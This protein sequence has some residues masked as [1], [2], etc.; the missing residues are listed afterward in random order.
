MTYVTGD[1]ER[2]FLA[3][4]GRKG[5][6]WQCTK[7]CFNNAALKE[8]D[9]PTHRHFASVRKRIE[10]DSKPRKEGDLLLLILSRDSCIWSYKC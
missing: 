5:G 8:Y 9:L 7:L 4:K 1:K 3:F 6:C 10:R 2:W